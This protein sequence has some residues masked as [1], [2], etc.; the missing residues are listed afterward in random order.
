MDL[1][2]TYTLHL[3]LQ[4]ITALHYTTLQITTAQAKSRSFIVFLSRCLLRVLKNG[5]SSA[6]VLTPL[7]L[8]Y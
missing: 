5:Y 4:V 3:E 2:T 8:A 1:L 7:L 6:S